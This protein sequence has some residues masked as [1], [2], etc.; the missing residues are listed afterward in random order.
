MTLHLKHFHS[1]SKNQSAPK[2]HRLLSAIF[3]S[4]NRN[5]S[6]YILT[7]K[8]FLKFAPWRPLAGNLFTRVLQRLL[9]NKTFMHLLKLSLLRKARKLKLTVQLVLRELSTC[10]KQSLCFSALLTGAGLL[11]HSWK[12]EELEWNRTTLTNQN[13]L[14]QQIFFCALVN[15]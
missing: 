12:K 13:E 4:I 15:I 9:F 6:N 1:N 5:Y 8:L 3:M 2:Y 10:L 11:K 7:L 14:S